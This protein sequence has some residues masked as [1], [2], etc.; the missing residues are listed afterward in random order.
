[1][2]TI[3]ANTKANG[4]ILPEPKFKRIPVRVDK[5]TIILVREGLNVEEHL[6]RFKDKDFN[7]FYIKK[8]ATKMIKS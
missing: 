4:D 3:K 2:R 1:M 6:K 5:N 8:R 7:L